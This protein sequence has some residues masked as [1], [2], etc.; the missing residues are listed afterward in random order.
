MKQSLNIGL[1]Y[2]LREEYLA[3]GY[4]QEETNEFDSIAHVEAM[5]GALERLGHR[6]ELIGNGRALAERLVLGVK[7]D[8]VFSTAEGLSGRSREAQVPALLELYD[9]PY[10]FSDATTMAITLDKSIAKRLIREA[11]IP[12]AA[13]MVAETGEENLRSWTYYPS[14]LKPVAEGTSKGCN[15]DSKVYMLES[16]LNV[17]EALLRRFRQPV[18]I[19]KF[20]PGREFTVGIIGKRGTNHIPRA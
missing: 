1:V 13:F 7:W 8:L 14:F 17:T 11:G 15:L 5:S 3:L 6:V 10:V 18:L 9:Q 4:T 2:D 16:L 19:E 12:T 20:L